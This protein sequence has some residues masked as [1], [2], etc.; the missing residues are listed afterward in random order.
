[1]R[2]LTPLGA[3]GGQVR[4]LREK[5]GLTLDDVARQI[6]RKYGLS[7]SRSRVGDIEN[8]R[9]SA[10][11][12]VLVVLCAALADLTGQRLS[13]AMLLDTARPVQIGP[14]YLV[15]PGALP[16]LF[17]GEAADLDPLGSDHQAGP[18]EDE[19]SQSFRA[20]AE[21]QLAVGDA[22]GRVS[23]DDARRAFSA[24]A[25]ADER[26]ATKL[27]LSRA[28]LVGYSLR[29]WGRLLSEESAAR[30]GEGTTPQKRGRITREL[31][32]EIEDARSHG[33]D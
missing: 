9:G 33:D 2:E 28:Q 5:H 26:A 25:L 27:G 24:A 19:L 30:A 8:G 31:L 18:D 14:R 12:E 23:E 6:Q 11:V 29:L 22:K 21:L 13:P 32:Q 15:A 17:R 20:F 7:W 3:I 16:A 1:M 4:L 10:T